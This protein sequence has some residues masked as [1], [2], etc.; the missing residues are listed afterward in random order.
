MEES[1][2]SLGGMGEVMAEVATAQREQLVRAN[3]ISR[4]RVRPPHGARARGRLPRLRF[5]LPMLAAVGGLALWW[6]TKDA[7]KAW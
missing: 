7:C 5:V 1:V 4:V 2:N 3:V 6:S